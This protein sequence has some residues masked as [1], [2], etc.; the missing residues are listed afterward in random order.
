MGG[1]KLAELVNFEQNAEQKNNI[2]QYYPGIL[3]KNGKLRKTLA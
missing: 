3:L 1:L 2:L